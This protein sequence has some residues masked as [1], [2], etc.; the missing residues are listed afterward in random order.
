MIIVRPEWYD[1]G[2][3]ISTA[4]KFL[5]QSG[6]E[7]GF[8]VADIPP[9]PEFDNGIP[10]LII[11]LPDRDGVPGIIRTLLGGWNLI[12]PPNFAKSWINPKKAAEGY[13][14]VAPG[15]EYEPGIRWAVLQVTDK[16]NPGNTSNTIPIGAEGPMVV[17]DFFDMLSSYGHKKGYVRIRLDGLVSRKD[18]KSDFRSNPCIDLRLTSKRLRMDEY[19]PISH[20]DEMPKLTYKVIK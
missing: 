18:L 4:E 8:T 15:L 7:K 14:K 19:H 11:N 9:C 1:F 5:I 12:N 20:D 13:V 10:F 16:N 3:I 17:A 6:S 2:K